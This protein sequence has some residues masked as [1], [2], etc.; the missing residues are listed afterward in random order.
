MR[1]SVPSLFSELVHK[2]GPYEGETES[3][4][5]YF[6]TLH[7]DA[8]TSHQLREFQNTFQNEKPHTLDVFKIGVQSFL[9]IANL[10]YEERHTFFGSQ[11]LGVHYSTD[12]CDE[13]NKL[14]PSHPTK[15]GVLTKTAPPAWDYV[16]E[17]KVLILAYDGNNPA[18]ALDKLLQG[19][20]T[21]DCGMC[22]QLSIWFGMRY[23]LGNEKFNKLFGNAPLYITQYLYHA[24]IDQQKP[25]TGNPLFDFFELHDSSS[26]NSAALAHI[27]NNPLYQIKHPGGGSQGENCVVIDDRYSM[28][29]PCAQKK[30]NLTKSEVKQYLVAKFNAPQNKHDVDRLAQM[31][32]ENPEDIDIRAQVSY[33]DFIEAAKVFSDLTISLESYEFPEIENISFNFEKFTA[34]VSLMLRTPA[35]AQYQPL[36]DA[37]LPS[38]SALCAEIPAENKDRMQFSTFKQESDLQRELFQT[39][40][41]FCDAIMQKKSRMLILTGNAGIGKTASAVCAAKELS[42]RGKNIVWISGIAVKS[43]PEKDDDQCRAKIHRLL[44]TNPDVV[45]LDENDLAAY[46]AA[47]ILDE[48][49][50]WYVK[51]SGKGVLITSSKPVTFDRRYRRDF[52]HYNFVPFLSYISEAMQGIVTRSNLSG[53]SQRPKIN[54]AVFKLTDEEKIGRL[55]ALQTNACSVGVFI[56]RDTYDANER[57]FSAVEFIP[58]IKTD[59]SRLGPDYSSL[60]EIQKRW[61]YSYETEDYDDDGRPL[62]PCPTVGIRKFKRTDHDIIAIEMICKKKS[63]YQ[64]SKITL[65]DA[66]NEQCVDQLLRVV[67]FAFDNGGKKVI[68]VNSTDFSQ[69]KLMKEI[70]KKINVSEKVPTIARINQ[71]FYSS[72]LSTEQQRLEEVHVSAHKEERTATPTQAPVQRSGSA[73]FQLAS[74]QPQAMASPQHQAHGI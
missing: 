6:Y 9:R 8:V 72:A 37:A 27:S 66:I 39:T 35:P 22:C 67:N 43:W 34:W 61:V 73:L 52:T 62:S 28:Y 3:A 1:Q 36:S 41:H 11:F 56:S 13:W 23:M 38:S 71:L 55:I 10:N 68:V 2:V 45:I 31:R 58:G 50:S 26:G 33:G 40:L 49:Y 7:R 44:A 20:T 47:V 24:I 51:N 63:V 70:I 60:T 21:I 12:L 64:D 54:R 57:N 46:F 4:D 29:S 17:N 16:L 19:P 15:A 59:G 5:H 48:C 30:L 18:E 42:A 65:Y 74:A 32:L 14:F 25:Y 53:E 69:K